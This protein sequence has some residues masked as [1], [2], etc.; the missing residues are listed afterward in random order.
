MSVKSQFVLVKTDARSQMNFTISYNTHQCGGI[1]KRQQGYISSPNFPNKPSK[2]VECAWLVKVDNEQAINLT[3]IDIN[4]GSDCE[5]S[6]L[7][8]YNGA[9]PTHPRIGKYCHDTK[10][11]TI[12]SQSNSL[13][14]EYKWE[15]GST[16]TGF[17]LK[18]EAMA[19]GE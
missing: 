16:G 12:I 17:K 7:S 5:K 4:L 6:F 1:S 18:Y 15:A 9:L 13:W 19:G 11:E 10:P 14:V 8:V 3:I 2:T